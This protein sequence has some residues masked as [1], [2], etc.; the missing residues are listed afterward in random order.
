[1]NFHNN[2]IRSRIFEILRLVL[3][4]MIIC[5]PMILGCIFALFVHDQNRA[6]VCFAVAIIG[7]FVISNIDKFFRAKSTK[8]TPLAKSNKNADPTNKR[9]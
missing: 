9:G 6:I 7:M 3:S 5:S 2:P 1:M 8:V 4:G